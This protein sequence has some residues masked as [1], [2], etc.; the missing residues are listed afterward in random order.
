M[1]ALDS[2]RKGARA[3]KVLRK[4]V[5]ILMTIFIGR[6]VPTR[7]KRF[8][9]LSVLRLC[10]DG[11]KIIKEIR[12]P[13]K[14]I[15]MFSPVP[16]AREKQMISLAD[17]AGYKTIFFCIKTYDQ[18]HT[19]DKYSTFVCRGPVVM[20]LALWAC[21]RLPLHVFSLDAISIIWLVNL[22]PSKIVLSLYDTIAGHN[23]ASKINLMLERAVIRSAFSLIH[24]DLRLHA[25]SRERGYILPSSNVYIP[26]IPRFISERQ[27]T[28]R[29][30]PRVVSVG[31]VGGDSN[32]L[33]VAEILAKEKIHLHAFFNPFQLAYSDEMNSYAALAQKTPYFHIEEPV[34]GNKLNEVLL[35]FDFGLAV[36]EPLVFKGLDR[37]IDIRYIENCGSSRLINYIEANLPILITPGLKYQRFLASRY[38]KNLIEVDERFYV[39]PRRILTNFLAQME[40]NKSRFSVE[41]KISSSKIY[42][43]KL[44][45]LYDSMVAN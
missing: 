22:R 40:L 9:G 19:S 2:I 38:T 10:E 1:S 34:F 6:L 39:S 32:I 16:H 28:N 33:R 21:A 36:Y 37:T 20:I 43:K 44:A 8:I 12:D 11:N 3:I 25:L 23:G 14:K 24:R 7:L 18:W 42:E 5:V 35:Q 41:K 15:F 30:E 4:I 45:Y 26:D 31:W 17:G 29:L 27:I 13:R